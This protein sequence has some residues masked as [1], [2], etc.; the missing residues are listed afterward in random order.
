MK[1]PQCFGFI[2][3][4]RERP[5]TMVGMVLPFCP[6]SVKVSCKKLEDKRNRIIDNSVG[7]ANS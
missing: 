2:K 5:E 1:K 6:C 7:R 4:R 3:Q